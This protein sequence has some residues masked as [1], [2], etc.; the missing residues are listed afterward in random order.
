MHTQPR[1][2]SDQFREILRIKH[3]SLSTEKT[4]INWVGQFIG[5]HNNRNPSAMGE[6]EVRDFLSYLARERN[7][8]SSTQDQ[9]FNAILFF[10]KYVLKRELALIDAVRAKRPKRLPVV[11]T[12]EETKMLLSHLSGV[13]GLMVRLLY[14]GGVRLME[15]HRLVLR[16]LIL[17]PGRYLS[18]PARGLRTG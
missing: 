16:I 1:K 10:Y 3:Y 13:K 7:V 5:F 14:G 9:A 11:L 18:V 6:K 4:Y 8:T 2:L 15:C 17:K 12:R